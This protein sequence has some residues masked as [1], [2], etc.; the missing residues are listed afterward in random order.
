MATFEPATLFSEIAA[1]LFEH[2]GS[3][4]T[5]DRDGNGVRWSYADA[6]A[7]VE[8]RSET[9]VAAL[10]MSGPIRDAAS[11]EDVR[12]VYAPPSD[13]YALTQRGVTHMV[14]DL[15]AFFSG[16]REPHFTFVDALSA[17]RGS[18]SR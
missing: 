16:V 14:E 4:L 7:V 2:F 15:V 1:P 8:Q 9:S 13:T 6:S 12:A 5:L 3:G 17:S 10:F 18:A 11:A